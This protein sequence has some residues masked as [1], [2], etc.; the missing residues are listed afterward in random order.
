MV[1]AGLPSPISKI[2]ESAVDLMWAYCA[3]PQPP[4][5]D[6]SLGFYFEIPV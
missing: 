6:R 5:D 4:A 3:G 1:A 2:L